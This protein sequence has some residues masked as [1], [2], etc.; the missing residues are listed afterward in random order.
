M[1]VVILVVFYYLSTQES[2]Y[3]VTNKVKTSHASPHF[4]YMAFK[5]AIL[6]M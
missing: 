2:R 4:K 3:N 1:I 6:F 5:S